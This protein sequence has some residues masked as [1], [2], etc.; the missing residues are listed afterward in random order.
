MRAISAKVGSRTE[1]SHCAGP[2]HNP[3]VNDPMEVVLRAL[4]ALPLA[5]VVV[6]CAISQPVVLSGPNPADG[7]GSV[8]AV[9]HTSVTAGTVN[10][11]PVAPRSWREMNDSVAPRAGRAP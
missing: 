4:A 9:A 11:W 2:G 8:A 10:Y 7:A 5:L 6:G 3:F 1:Q